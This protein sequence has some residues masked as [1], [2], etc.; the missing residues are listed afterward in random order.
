MPRLLILSILL[1]LMAAMVNPATANTAAEITA[2][3]TTFFQQFVVA[4]GQIVWFVL[5]PLSVAMVYLS[6]EYFLTIRRK[7]I[8]PNGIGK[9]I[10]AKIRNAP[11][12]ETAKSL[13]TRKDFVSKAVVYAFAQT[14][15][16]ENYSHIRNLMAESLQ[17]QGMLFFRK[18]EWAHIIGNVSPM[19]GLFGTV[20]GMIKAFNGIVMTG[21]QPQPA[22][23][24]EGISIALVTT[25][26]GLLIGI[27]ALVIHGVF[28]N[29]IEA[30]V[31]DAAIEAEVVLQVLMDK[32]TIQQ[33][34]KKTESQN[35]SSGI[36]L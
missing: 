14:N 15:E 21:G 9:E 8:S 17:E 25:F 5:L 30:L 10:A 33:P 1:C 12:A 35:S 16:E 2:K 7:V 32:S 27:P 4:G 6:A 20:F 23:L 29:R 19:V 24:A 11:I 18:I 3:Q 26:W 34:Q 13:R 31:S 22:Q 36:R 28:R